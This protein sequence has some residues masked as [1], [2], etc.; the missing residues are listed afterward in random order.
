VLVRL[1]LR[2]RASAFVIT[3]TC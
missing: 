2:S 1:L 3:F